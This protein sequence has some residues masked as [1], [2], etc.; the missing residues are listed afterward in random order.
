MLT[1]LTQHIAQVVRLHDPREPAVCPRIA[2]RLPT[3]KIESAFG[4]HA[5]SRR[6]HAT[7]QHNM[8]VT[9]P[10]ANGPGAVLEIMS[11]AGDLQRATRFM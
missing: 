4:R 7:C 6:H 2:R 9:R 1:H 5:N 8:D 10:S 11:T 3:H